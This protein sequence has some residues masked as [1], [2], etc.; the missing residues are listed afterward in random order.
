MLSLDKIKAMDRQQ[1][2]R[3]VWEQQK[4][5]N[6]I[7]ELK[8]Q[9]QEKNAVAIIAVQGFDSYLVGEQ[10]KCLLLLDNIRKHLT[11]ANND[12]SIRNNS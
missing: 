1:L 3:L 12:S 6:L 7:A 4:I 11:N 2:M 10:E 5:V 9:C 8:L